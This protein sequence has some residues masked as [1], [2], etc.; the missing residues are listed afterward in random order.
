MEEKTD[1]LRYSVSI[2]KSYKIFLMICVIISFIMAI[3][4][5]ALTVG[6]VKLYLII[7]RL[8]L[9]FSSAYFVV[10]WE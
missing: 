8:F 1:K 3:W 2:K 4:C 9:L 7:W 6:K 10:V 5:P